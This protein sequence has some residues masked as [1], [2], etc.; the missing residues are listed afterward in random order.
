MRKRVDGRWEYEFEIL[1]VLWL[2]FKVVEVMEIYVLEES[3][4]WMLKLLR[5]WLGRD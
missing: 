1:D 4:M 2:S 3:F 5:I